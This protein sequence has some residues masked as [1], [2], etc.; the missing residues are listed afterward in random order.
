MCDNNS[1]EVLKNIKN[2]LKSCNSFEILF[3]SFAIT[4]IIIM[5]FILND[6][7]IALISA[8]CGILYTVVAGKGKPYCYLFG[9]IG[10]VCYC[11]LAYK[12]TLYGNLLLNGCYYLPMEIIGFFAWNK[13]L[14]KE[15]NEIEKTSLEKHK[16]TI[17]YALMFLSGLIFSFVLKNA[18]DKFFVLD[19]FITILSIGAMY[20]TVKRCVQQWLIW[21]VVNTLSI[22]VW[23]NIYTTGSKTF[24]TLLMWSCYF[25]LGIYFYIKWEKD[26]IGK[27]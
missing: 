11:Y 14:K 17:L 7:K 18:G 25:V 26:L 16:I 8:V 9:I 21:T 4:A 23:F 20:L 24:S 27:E 3:L 13:H 5:Y 22:I 10:T 1:M 6:S 19:S 12:S 2:E 15:T